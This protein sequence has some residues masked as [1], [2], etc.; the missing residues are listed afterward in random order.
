VGHGF[1]W[2]IIRESK[3]HRDRVRCLSLS[4][5]SRDAFGDHVMLLDSPRARNEAVAVDGMRVHLAR[6][7][8]QIARVCA[9]HR[10]YFTEE[11][12]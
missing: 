3:A 8:E 11:D 7:L 10:A 9:D 2:E 12:T 5:A 1:A 6:I 4:F